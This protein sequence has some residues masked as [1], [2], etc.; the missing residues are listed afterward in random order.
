MRIMRKEYD[1]LRLVDAASFVSSVNISGQI[2]CT[3]KTY[4]VTALCDH[5]QQQQQQQQLQQ[6]VNKN[7]L[8]ETR[9]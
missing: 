2:S 8:V 9:Q 7:P 6:V 5:A 3:G 4:S 1:R